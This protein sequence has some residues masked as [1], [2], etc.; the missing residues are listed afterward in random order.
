MTSPNEQRN[1]VLTRLS[2]AVLLLTESMDPRLITKGSNISYAITG[3][4]ES[5]GVAAISGGFVVEGNS[6]RAPGQ[7]GYG[8]DP[9]LAK[10]ILTA[11]KFDPEMRCAATIRYSDAVRRV[12]DDM[13]LE[14]CTIN[15]TAQ[16]PGVD[17]MDWGI[18]SCCREGVPEAII[19]PGSSEKVA[20][21]HLFGEDPAVVS[22]NIIMLSNRII[23]IEL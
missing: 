18:A 9:E 19:D 7:C 12:L 20:V 5:A 23:R 3:A 15:R 16:P 6:V 14:C 13:F 10:I 21:I 1:E 11:A 2:R 8:T 17:T 22:G 4:R